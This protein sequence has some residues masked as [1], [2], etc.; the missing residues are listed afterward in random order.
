[1]APAKE[2]THHDHAPPASSGPAKGTNA[3]LSAFARMGG[4]RARR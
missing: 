4:C 1:M 3:Q 2:K